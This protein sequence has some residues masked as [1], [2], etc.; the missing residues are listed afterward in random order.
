MPRGVPGAGGVYLVLQRGYLVLRGVPGPRE[1]YLPRGTCPG[2]APPPVNRMTD[3]RK[4]ITLPQTSFVGGN[5]G[6]AL[7]REQNDRQA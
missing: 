5:T 4:N 3:R 2:T 1:V 6:T 7:P